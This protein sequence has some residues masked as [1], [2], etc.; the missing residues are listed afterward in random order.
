MSVSVSVSVGECE[1]ECECVRLVLF[2]TIPQILTHHDLE[3]VVSN[4]ESTLGNVQKDW[5][6]RV[7]AVSVR[8]GREVGR[9]RE[10]VG[11]RRE[12]V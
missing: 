7:S 12:E 5:E 11:R 10:E 9:R 1:C 4:I 8:E 2:C 6:Q 3:R